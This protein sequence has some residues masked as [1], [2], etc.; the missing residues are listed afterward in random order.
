MTM[1]TADGTEGQMTIVAPDLASFQASQEGLG[2]HP[3]TLVATSNG[4]QIAV[5][6]SEQTSLEEAI[7]IA[8]RIQQGDPPGLVQ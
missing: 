6:L 7:R 8:S 1:V 5:Q 2:P 3:V 4:T